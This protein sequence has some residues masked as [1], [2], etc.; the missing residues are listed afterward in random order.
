MVL[1]VDFHDECVRTWHVTDASATA[2]RNDGYT[3]TLF[4]HGPTQTTLAQLREHVDWQ[5]TVVDTA[6]ESHR[7]GFRY[8]AEPMLRVDVASV[9]AVTPL[10]RRIRSWGTPGEY[11][12]FDVDLSPEFRYCLETGTA[13]TPT[14]DRELRV[15]RLEATEP[16]LAADELAALTI[17]GSTVDGPDAIL[18]GLTEHL[19]THDP[20]V[21]VVSHAALIPRLFELADRY[22]H[23]QF[24]L[25]RAPGYRQRASQSTYTSYGRVGHSPARYSVPG[26][27]LINE[28]ASFLWG[29]TNLA[30]C[31]DLAARSGKPLQEVAWASIGTVLTALQIQE[32]HARDVR[33]PWNSWRHERFKSMRT[34]HDADRGGFTFE[35]AVGVHED[36]HEIDF[37]SLYPNIM[38]TRNVSPET[39]RCGCHDTDD[40][41]GLGYSLCP[42][43]GY[44]P[45]VL[46]PLVAD[47]QAIKRELADDPPPARERALQGRADAIKWILVSCFGYQGFANAKFGRIEAHEAINAFARELLLDAKE[48]LE[49]GGWRVIHG[50]VDSLWVTPASA[51]PEPIER[52]CA[53]VTAATDIPLEH[54]AS[55][56]WIAFVPQ[57]DSDSGALTKYF[58][59]E[60]DSDAY[61][62][63]GIECRQ[64]STCAFVERVQRQ[65]IEA[66][67]THRAPEPVCD[68]LQRPLARLAE[69]KV[70]ATA[71][72]RRQRVSQPRAAYDGQTRTVAALE[73]AAAAGVEVH[74]GESV[75]F[76]VA[77]DTTG[78]RDRVRL[79]FEVEPDTPYDAGFYR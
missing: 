76:L 61:K 79:D 46:E 41:P 35:P 21:L 70:D 43:R 38:V 50:I 20:D 49:A 71:L 23:E 48:R 12:L 30:G 32:A 7:P 57:Q 78:T 2:E 4:V 5:P 19:A 47:R 22:N 63:R 18:D 36:V 51:R 11:R 17:D 13:P 10:A 24:Q 44:L 8:D 67:D 28:Q 74:P 65:L 37:A 1:T 68:R 16:A 77:D 75:T 33:V 62:I 73:R 58:G 40:V 15:C 27:V 60:R 14:T 3:P 53:A 55:Y 56:D 42:N 34:L 59:A 9:D 52:V 69:G 72:T 54:E 25:G 29:E 31:L 64:R 45:D 66:F 26:R 6:V 39:V